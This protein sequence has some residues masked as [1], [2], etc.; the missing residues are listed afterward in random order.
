MGALEVVEIG[1]KMETSFQ[2]KIAIAHW[3]FLCYNRI[4]IMV[5]NVVILDLAFNLIASFLI[6][7]GRIFRS[8]KIIQNESR[9]DKERNLE[10]ERQRLKETR[11]VRLDGCYGRR[12]CHSDYRQYFL[13]Q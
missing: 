12:I 11:I 6:A 4:L 5:N 13:F 1:P 9:T 3:C 7:Y 2:L 10:E 8:K